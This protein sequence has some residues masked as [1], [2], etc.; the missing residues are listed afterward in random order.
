MLE[1]FNKSA[2]M[3]GVLGL[4]FL[5]F[6]TTYAGL[7]IIFIGLAGMCLLISGCIRFGCW[8]KERKNGV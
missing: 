3:L 1:T 7:G 6:T 2:A 8:L 4:I 5:L